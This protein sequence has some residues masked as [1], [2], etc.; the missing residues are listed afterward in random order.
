MTLKD[1]LNKIQE[2]DFRF[3]S[4]LTNYSTFRLRSRGDIAIVKSEQ[5]LE[6]LLKVLKKNNR[7]WRMIG[8]GANQVLDVVENDFLIQIDFP[9]DPSIFQKLNAEYEL[10][11]SVGLNV[12]TAHAIK[13]SI[14]GWEVF[15]GIPA[16]LGGAI[17]MN[18]GTAL[19]EIGPLIK[20]VRVMDETG[21]IRTEVMQ[22]GS[23]SYRKNNFLKK[24]EIILS[25]CLSHYGVDTQ[26]PDKIKSYQEYRRQ[27]QPLSTKN[28]GCVFKNFSKTRQA[29]RLLDLTGLKGLSVGA[30]SISKKH[31]NFMENA[32][33]ASADD[34][35][36]LTRL[37]NQQMELHWGVRFELEVKAV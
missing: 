14:K 33:N 7:S 12:L 19:G 21:K 5:S 37:I 27:S 31:A 18:A 30:L 20:S 6:Q 1:E 32:S 11:A 25:A 13:F 3:D 16:S 24:N 10:P 34:F 23:F 28:C 22:T 29:G 2:I 15:T 8:W 26:I 9:V 4:D 35:R 17:F 36:E